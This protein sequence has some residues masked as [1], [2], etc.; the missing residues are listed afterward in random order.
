MT[1]ATE[2]QVSYLTS[3]IKGRYADLGEAMTAYGLDAPTPAT[4]TKYD[5]SGMIE[6][7]KAAE[8][9]PEQQAKVDFYAD[10]NAKQ[11]ALM[12]Q[13]IAKEITMAEYNE[14]VAAL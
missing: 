11:A 4:L 13:L 6:W 2:K 3:L 14:L 8:R 10:R 9:S 5:A 12:Q 1:T 7:L